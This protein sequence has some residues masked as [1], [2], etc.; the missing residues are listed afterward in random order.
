MKILHCVANMAGGG[1]ERQV[2]ILARAQVDSGDDV[3][4]ALVSGGPNLPGLEEAGARLHWIPARSYYDPRILWNLRQTIRAIRPQIVQSWLLQMDVAAGLA[5]LWCGSPWVLCERVSGEFYRGWAKG[6][7]RLHLGKLAAAIVA[8]SRAGAEYW[9]ARYGSRVR[10]VVIPNAVPFE[11]ISR[12]P[13][14]SQGACGQDQPFILFAGRLVSQKNPL[15]MIEAIT[16]VLR[17]I[18]GCAVICGDG[19][20]ASSLQRFVQQCGMTDRVRFVGYRADLWSLMKSAAVFVSVSLFEGHPNAV[21][22]AMACRCPLV[23]SDIPEHREFLDEQSA[24][25]PS[26]TSL[27]GI[28]ASITEAIRDQALAVKKTAAAWNIVQRYTPARC[29][30]QYREVYREVVRSDL[31]P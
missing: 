14:P 17:G 7:L 1:A 10:T 21:L 2:G 31:E 12:A 16:Q 13:I 6:W 22:E 11:S 24:W 15:V 29:A 8:N 20:Q 9:H 3:H 19:P 25:L 18:D 23:V 26:P 28:V 5:A 27:K 30:E 4:V